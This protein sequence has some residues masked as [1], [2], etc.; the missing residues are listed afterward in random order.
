MIRPG[1]GAGQSENV[2]TCIYFLD[3][4]SKTQ[5]KRV[6][7][8]SFAF[9]NQ[10]FAQT[11]EKFEGTSVPPPHALRKSGSNNTIEYRFCFK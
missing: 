5:V 7:F 11:K 10:H 4:T 8:G 1:V 9:N 6:F 2:K 3:K